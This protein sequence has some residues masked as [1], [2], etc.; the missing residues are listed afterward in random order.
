MSSRATLDRPPTL[1]GER[2][3]PSDARRIARQLKVLADPARVR[4]LSL[5]RQA[6]KGEA[7][8]G[9]LI[10]P[11]KL[12][13]PTVSHHLKVLHEAGFLGRERRGVWVWYR[14][15]PAAIDRLCAVFQSR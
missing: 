13:Q 15:L 10:S 4:L 2:L 5:I 9:A 6:P 11:L 12:S 14:F 3:S 8:V 1:L 7:C